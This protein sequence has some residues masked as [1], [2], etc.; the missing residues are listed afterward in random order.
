MDGEANGWN[1]LYDID[2]QLVTQEIVSQLDIVKVISEKIPLTAHGEFLSGNCTIYDG[3]LDNGK[4]SLLVSPSHKLFYCDH[5]ESGGTVI[6][7]LRRFNDYD[8]K[9]AILNAMQLLNTNPQT[10]TEM[11]NRKILKTHRLISDAHNYF[12]SRMTDEAAEF[13]QEK[14]ITRE[15]RDDW[16]IGFNDGT[17]RSYF[18]S[19]GA[20]LEEM[21]DT[22]LFNDTNSIEGKITFPLIDESGFA[23]GIAGL[24]TNTNKYNYTF[25][26]RFDTRKILFGFH[27]A[28]KAWEMTITDD[29]LHVIKE[30]S[31]NNKSIVGLAHRYFTDENAEMLN[32]CG[33]MVASFLKPDV[34]MLAKAAKTAQK[35]SLLPRVNTGEKSM[36][37][38]EYMLSTYKKNAPQSIS[39][40]ER[41]FSELINFSNIEPD[42]VHRILL[43]N[44]AA[45]TLGIPEVFAELKY[46]EILRNNTSPVSAYREKP[47]NRYYMATAFLMHMI[48][49]VNPKEHSKP[50]A[51]TAHYAAPYFETIP[52]SSW[53]FD[54]EPP[55]DDPLRD[56]YQII[57]DYYETKKSEPLGQ[58]T[59][60]LQKPTDHQLDIFDAY[61]IDESYNYV[62]KKLRERNG[63]MPVFLTEELFESTRH[64]IARKMN[65][66]K[67]ELMDV[68]KRLQQYIGSRH[69]RSNLSQLIGAYKKGDM[70]EVGTISEN[71]RD[72]ILQ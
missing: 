65:G 43:I 70:A 45:K 21:L 19:L 59:L 62:S 48:A 41:V 51:S 72:I 11:I 20:S 4:N 15:H 3:H 61:R 18:E 9:N 10:F 55:Y 60:P 53:V 54:A 37:I 12:H 42:P 13:L 29:Y 17:L 39:D 23:V 69:L 38:F 6:D 2:N 58:A 36:S 34:K 67:M 30:H 46:A 68:I 25:G 5:C 50:L 27:G 66:H 16:K 47:N 71:T 49:L 44:E 28:E 14:G 7:F 8:S 1:I 22:N 24:D 52:P 40:Q 64:T 32:Y 56:A 63:H 26:K 35:H 33:V 31:T 57:I